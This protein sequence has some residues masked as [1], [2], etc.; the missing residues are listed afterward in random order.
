QAAADWLFLSDDTSNPE[1]SEETIDLMK[2]DGGETYAIEPEVG[3]AGVG[4]LG[5]ETIVT[6]VEQIVTDSRDWPGERRGVRP[7]SRDGR[8]PGATATLEEAP[9]PTSGGTTCES[10]QHFCAQSP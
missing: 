2:A 7:P 8:T 9:R 5:A 3:I 10:A 6:E 1:L 4:P